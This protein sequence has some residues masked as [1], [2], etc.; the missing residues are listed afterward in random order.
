[1]NRKFIL[2]IILLL[3]V[4]GAAFR[5][6][7]NKA[8]LNAAKQ[9]VDRSAIAI[10]VTVMTAAMAP[11]S[12]SFIVP[13]TLEPYDHAKVMLNAQGKLAS[14]SVDLGSYVTKG[15]VI[16]SLDLAQKRLELEA[17]ELSMTRLK[18]DY[19]RFTELL[20]GKATSQMSFDDM[21]FQY[22]NAKVKVE[23]IRQQIRDSQVIAPVSGTVVA[24]NVEVGEFVSA[25]TAVVEVVD[26]ARLKAKV[27]VSESDAYRLRKDQKVSLSTSIYPGEVFP[28][29]VTFVSPRGDANHNYE[30]EVELTNSK[31][32]PLK[33][34]TFVT[35]SFSDNAEGEAILI[36]K[37]ALG[38]GLKDPY[39]FLVERQDSSMRATRQA[40]TL[41]REVGDRIAVVGGLVPGQSVV[42]TGQLN[43]AEGT[44]VRITKA[45]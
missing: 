40:I 19:E 26:V 42:L 27:Y 8:E 35:A 1:M 6:A 39:I 25:N 43:L 31:D 33:S 29:K 38:E 7:S 13:G 5:L 37:T 30:V 16:G 34:G 28:G 14:L 12:D 2:P 32:H 18:K 36:P 45:N 15:Q 3:V 41:G 9:P 20:E 21:E 4:L 17:A 23:Q 24:K 44:L 11:L 22:L 10:P